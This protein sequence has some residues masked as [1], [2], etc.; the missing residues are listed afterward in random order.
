MLNENES[1]VQLQPEDYISP[2]QPGYDQQVLVISRQITFTVVVPITS[3]TGMDVSTAIAYEQGLALPEVVE[4]LQFIDES[5]DP[6]NR[7]D[8]R[9][10]VNVRRPTN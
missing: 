8:L 10:S 7:I 2:D 4:A 6:E 3:Y 5:E 9:T 1:R